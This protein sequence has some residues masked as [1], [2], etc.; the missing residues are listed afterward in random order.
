M[1]KL[2]LSLAAA[3]AFLAAGFSTNRADAVT[4]GNPGGLDAAIKDNNITEQ[5]HCVPGWWH[6]PHSSA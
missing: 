3:A 5:V 2:T 4:L 6:Q 1:R